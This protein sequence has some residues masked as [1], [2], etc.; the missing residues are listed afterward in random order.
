MFLETSIE[1]SNISRE[2]WQEVASRKR[3]E[4]NEKI[5]P[6][7]KIPESLLAPLGPLDD[8][9]NL[10]EEQN[11]LTTRELELTNAEAIEVVSNIAAAV[12]TSEEVTRAICKRAA[13]AQQLTNCLTEIFFDEALARAKELDQKQKNKESLGPLHGLPISLKDQ[14]NV[15]GIDATIGYVSRCFKPATENC[16]LVDILLEAGAVLYCKTNVPTTL[17]SGE[18]VNNVFGRT[19]NPFN[20]ALSSGG[21]S[22]GESA[23]IALK[24]SYLGVGTDIGGS[25]RHPCHWTGLFGLRPSHGRVSYHGA[26]NTY[27]GQEAL[28]SCA[29]PMA[30]SAA[31][32][33][34]FMSAL[35]ASKPW[36][37]DPQ[38]IPMPWRMEGGALPEK[39]C[40]GIGWHDNSVA[41]TPPVRRA[42]EIAKKKLVDAGHNVIDYIPF[43]S[44]E[45]RLIVDKMC[46]ADGGQEFQRD[47]D[48][49]GEPLH[50]KIESWL[51]KT[52]NVKP[53][54]VFETWQNQHQRTQLAQKWSKRWEATV[55]ETGTGRP[56]DALIM[57]SLPFPAVPHDSLYTSSY[58]TLCPLLDLTTGEFP[59]TKVDLAKDKMPVGQQP[60]SKL[61]EE[62][63]KFYENPS[64]FENSRVGLSVIGRRLEEEKVLAMLDLVSDI[65]GVDT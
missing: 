61:D 3:Q 31:D 34:L 13:L 62:A 57:P 24:G 55:S 12:W 26:A 40:F 42:L 65:V 56:I 51:G 1:G 39:L 60:M 21:S 2:P 10:I 27:L 19:S 14:F 5:S 64:K 52:A 22:G 53:M 63:M 4:R 29:G 15:K 18:T 36:L 54:T 6:A 43:E 33:K 9:S 8:V 41:P 47:A 16:I 17:M 23:L 35:A 38:C 28:R 11:L 37:Q 44:V 45:G 7:W 25:I 59:V 46:C 58:N 48:A 30:R 20:R 32:L 49:S 50:F